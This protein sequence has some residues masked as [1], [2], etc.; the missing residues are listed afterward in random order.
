MSNNPRRNQRGIHPRPRPSLAVRQRFLIVC[1][2]EKT[3]PNYFRAYQKFASVIDVSIHGA[4]ADPL[5]V[6]NHASSEIELER[7]RNNLSS[8]AKPYDQVWCVF[9]RDDWLTERFNEALSQ[10]RHRKFQVA[11]SNQ[12]FE[13]RYVLHFEFLNSSIRR[14]DYIRKLHTLLR[15]PYK[16]NDPATFATLHRRQPIAIENAKRLLAEYAPAAPATDDPS[17]TIHLLI[18]ALN[19]FLI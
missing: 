15:K 6:V 14:A 3:E 13:L 18:L 5:S 9:D 8:R 11:Y 19:R 1:E 16:K 7:Q 17:T 12:A 4:G 10:A 2:G